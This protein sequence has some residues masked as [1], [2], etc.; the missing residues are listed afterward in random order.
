M[1]WRPAVRLSKW[2]ASVVPAKTLHDKRWPIKDAKK[3][4]QLKIRLG[5]SDQ[6]P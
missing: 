5:V 2:I 6:S 4:K 1:K 3:P